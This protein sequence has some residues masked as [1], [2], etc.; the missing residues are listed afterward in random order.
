MLVYN[1]TSITFMYAYYRNDMAKTWMNHIFWIVLFKIKSVVGSNLINMQK[2]QLCRRKKPKQN[3][4]FCVWYDEQR[5]VGMSS[6][7]SVE[8]CATVFLI[9][10]NEKNKIW[11]GKNITFRSMKNHHHKINNNLF[12]ELKFPRTNDS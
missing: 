8:Q 1:S 4:F 12:E 3:T 7:N 10:F 11:L 9:G 6:H 5:E 2:F